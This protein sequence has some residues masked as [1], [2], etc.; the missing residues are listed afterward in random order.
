M[1]PYKNIHIIQ[2][3]SSPSNSPKLAHKSP[4]SMNNSSKLLKKTV[5]FSRSHVI[6]GFFFFFFSFVIMF[7]FFPPVFVCFMF[8]MHLKYKEER[9][10]IFFFFKCIMN[11][12]IKNIYLF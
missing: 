2:K 10:Q 4:K 3:G 11:I 12:K 7:I 5:S 6:H 8:F 1:G 9:A